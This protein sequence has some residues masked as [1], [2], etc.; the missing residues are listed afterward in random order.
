MF[1]NEIFTLIKIYSE[2][3]CATYRGVLYAKGDVC[4][5]ASCGTC[6][7]DGCGSKPGGGSNCCVGEIPLQQVC[8]PRQDAPCHLESKGK[9]LLSKS[10]STIYNIRIISIVRVI[11]NLSINLTINIIRN[12]FWSN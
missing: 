7:G 5:A 6:G 2:L 11:V 3:P 9:R 8:G 12:N 1:N 4:C 10:N